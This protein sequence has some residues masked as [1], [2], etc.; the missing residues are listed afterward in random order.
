MQENGLGFFFWGGGGGG[1]GSFFGM[2][3]PLVSFPDS[4]TVWPGDEMLEAPLPLYVII[5][6]VT[7]LQWNEPL[8]CGHLGDLV[9]CPIKRG[10][11]ISRVNLH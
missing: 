3:T 10:V 8:Y 2:E 1:R 9:K 5:I 6:A 7:Q 4:M 11:L